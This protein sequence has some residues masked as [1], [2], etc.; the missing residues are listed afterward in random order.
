MTSKTPVQDGSEAAITGRATKEAETSRSSATTEQVNAGPHISIK[1][2]EVFM[3]QGF[4]V[5]NS[6]LLSFFTF[7]V[8]LV[9]V[10]KY[11]LDS[12]KKEKSSLFYFITFAQRS[13][14]DF[15]TSAMGSK[16]SKYFS[17]LGAFFFFI[18]LQN[19]SGLLPG[20][21]SVLLHNTP[22]L[23]ANTADLNTTLALGLVSVVAIQ[24]FGIKEVGIKDYLGKFFN[25]SSP[26]AF[27]VGIL[28]IIS[29]FS[30]ILSFAFRL[31]GNIF[32]GEVLL[33]VVAFLVPVLVSFPFLMLETF[34]GLIQ[35]VVFAMLS[36]VLINLATT[37]AHH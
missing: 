18:L 17:L 7:L 27:F 24:V 22:L 19:W 13:L 12:Q 37:K 2:E 25:F 8:F 16:T 34:V 4:P 9:L 14:F 15:F 23:R 20:V 10:V 36:A 32:A 28:E 5:T 6:L 31:F 29:E 3:I 30:R 33:T 21:G 26:I 35:A 11:N 1:A